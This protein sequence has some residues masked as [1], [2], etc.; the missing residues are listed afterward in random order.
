MNEP[1][2]RPRRWRRWAVMAGVVL[3]AALV[4]AAVDPGG[5]RTVRLSADFADVYPMVVGSQVKL[6]GVPVGQVVAIAPSGRLARVDMELDPEVLP[7]HTDAKV[8]ITPADLLGERFIS[9]E[10]GTPSAPEMV[11]P[12]TL[13]R[14]QTNRVVDLQ[15]VLNAVDTPT[16][17]AL[18]AMITATGEGLR[19]NG[20]RTA[21]AI[22]TVTPVM[23]QIG[24]L[25]AVL[26]EQNDELGALIDRAAPVADGLAGRRGEDLDHLVGS[27]TQT[28]GVLSDQQQAVRETL[29]RLPE[30][31]AGAR[32]TLGQVAAV[33]G[34]TRDTLA[35][36]RPVTDNLAD[37][38]TELRRFTDAAD[39]A[40]EALPPVLD[41][42]KKLVDEAAPVANALRPAGADLRDIA[43]S[44][45][46]L[47]DQALSPR[48]EH[49]MEFLKGWALATADY[50]TVSHYFKAMVPY[51]P[52]AAGQAVAGP[53][54]GAPHAP[55]PGPALPAPP[56][57]RYDELGRLLPGAPAKPDDGGN[58]TGLRPEQERSMLDNLLGGTR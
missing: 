37:I 12:G 49:L 25:A 45:R 53:I 3:L 52:K 33:A 11:L 56:A 8:T 17:A 32:R 29:A 26:N 43:G 22:T 9:L 44:A 41:R 47:S 24:Q 18:A 42:A 39:P 6:A 54:P 10:R 13:P 4:T 51:T 38:S 58:A 23:R 5:K 30:A 15:D 2:N 55:V 34:P 14:P 48:M 1:E 46:Q 40:L 31:M 16:S 28:L 7:L 57:P 20:A 35:S 27:T 19:G 21:S 50:D 36:I